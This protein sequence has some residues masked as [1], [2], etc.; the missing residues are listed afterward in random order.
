[1]TLFNQKTGD[2]SNWILWRSERYKLLLAFLVP[3]CLLRQQALSLHETGGFF[4]FMFCE[5]SLILSM[6]FSFKTKK[7]CFF[8][9]S[10]CTVGT[11]NDKDLN[12]AWEILMC[13]DNYHDQY[14]EG[15][16]ECGLSPW[17]CKVNQLQ[18]CVGF[19]FGFFW[20]LLFLCAFEARRK[21]IMWYGIQN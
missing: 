11:V 7:K 19:F 14:W 20:L 17:S 2:K 13:L 9:S 18:S 4:L 1:M 6:G 10:V 8:L 5:L 15:R 12:K 16:G 21:S 3:F